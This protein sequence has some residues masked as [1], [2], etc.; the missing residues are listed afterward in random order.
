MSCTPN[1]LCMKFLLTI[2]GILAAQMPLFAQ[3]MLFPTRERPERI[4]PFY[5]K[6]QRI[7]TK[8]RDSVAETSVEQTFVNATSTEQEGTYLYPLPEGASPTTFSMMVGERTLEPRILR[9]EEAR[10]I[11]EGIVRQR[12]DPALLEYVGRDLVR[13]SVYPIPAHG[14]RVIKMRYTE[15]LKPE[16][17]MRKYAYT[18]STSRFGARPVGLTTV[19]IE[20]HTTNPLKNVFSPSHDVSLRRPDDRSATAT[21]EGSNESSDR[22]LQL[23]FS[24]SD[25]DIGLSLLTY[26]TGE[27]DGYFMLLASPRISIPKQKILPK[28]IVFVL[29]RTGSMSGEKIQQARKALL[30]CLNTLRPEDRFNVI[31]F[32]ES[33]DLFSRNLEPANA[34]NVKRAVKFVENVEASGGT[35]ID[36][37]LR[38]AMKQLSQERSRQKMIVFLTDGLATVGETN[39]DT[40]LQH[41]HQ[42]NEE[43]A[44]LAH[45]DGARLA[46]LPKERD[47]SSGKTRIFSFGVGYDVNVPFLDKLGQQN[48]GDSDFVK[49]S[50]DIEVKVSSFFGKVTSPILTNLQLA[51]DGADVYDVFPKSYPD[52]FKGS[53]LVITGRYRG[54]GRGTVRLTGLANETRETFKLAS[55]LG[56]S[57]NRSNFLP[58]IWA[59]RKIGFLV[60]QVRLSNQPEGKKELIDE[61]IRLSK[62]YGIITEYTSFLV[63][64]REGINLGFRDSAG[65]YK[66]ELSESDSLKLREEV[67]R[68]T[69]QGVNGENVTNQS[70]RAKAYNGIEKIVERGQASA[71]YKFYNYSEAPL[72]LGAGG[73]GGRISGGRAGGT[74][75]AIGTG[76]TMGG[77]AGMLGRG[78][79]RART[80]PA[81]I[82]AQAI[83]GKT[84][85]R[86]K[87]NLWQ[88]NSYSQDKQKITLIQAYSDAHFALMRAVPNLA[89]YSS[90]GDQVLI[91][92]GK[93]AIQI[94]KEGKEKLTSAEIRALTAP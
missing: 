10:S 77:M 71:D 91:K 22:D 2:A 14:E 46:G 89:A 82:G 30:F 48:K 3:G 6:S 93:N 80:E 4:L 13:I 88:D 86:Q 27:R 61:I 79:N 66:R 78:A 28:Q 16:N 54:E 59:M 94:G 50:E 85:Y 20:L 31:T 52:L 65:V 44:R 63:D 49:P 69:Q 40:I 7:Q 58:R 24:T 9:K 51:F 55:N 74:G 8:I 25:D 64:E 87:N 81:Q 62:D 41:V 26:R 56:D 35:N 53:Q 29:D 5:I 84:F 43:S 70:L 23:Y 37:A 75:G 12:R 17:G 57:D 92:L 72:A 34:D 47:D 45:V 68:R 1:R 38:S 67:L 32:N 33:P 36:E 42:Q 15:V 76:V 73:F 18:L 90:V 11:Y 39:I 83:G 19:S 21:W 60:D